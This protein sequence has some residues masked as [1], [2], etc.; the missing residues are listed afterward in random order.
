MSLRANHPFQ[1]HLGIEF[2]FG[3]ETAVNSF[4]SQRAPIL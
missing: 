4:F 3:Y 2:F 1:M